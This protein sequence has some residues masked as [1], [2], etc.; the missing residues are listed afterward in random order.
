MKYYIY[1]I[2][3]NAD[4]KIYGCFDSLSAAKMSA[5]LSLVK[6][7]V[8]ILTDDISRMYFYE[9]GEWVYDLLNDEARLSFLDIYPNPNDYKI[10]Y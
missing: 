5:S 2:D 10:N 4:T 1:R 9:N 7:V 3:E 8:F 6:D